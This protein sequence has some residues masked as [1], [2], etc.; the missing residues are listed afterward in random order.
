MVIHNWMKI[1]CWS[2]RAIYSTGKWKDEKGPWEMPG[3]CLGFS[4]CHLKLTVHLSCSIQES[5]CLYTAVFWHVNASQL[6]VLP[7]WLLNLPVW[8]NQMCWQDCRVHTIVL[9][10]SFCSLM[11]LKLIIAHCNIPFKMDRYHQI[12]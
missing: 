3:K 1:H 6:L 10:E 11:T 2:E 7:F 5:A 9:S 4:L 8:S 12:I